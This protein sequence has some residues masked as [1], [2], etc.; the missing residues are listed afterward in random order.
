MLLGSDL[1]EGVDYC[2]LL[3]FLFAESLRS[4]PKGCGIG[5]MVMLRYILYF[6]GTSISMENLL[7]TASIE[8]IIIMVFNSSILK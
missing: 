6:S 5:M 7:Y 2:V 8:L 1:V 4:I 3:F